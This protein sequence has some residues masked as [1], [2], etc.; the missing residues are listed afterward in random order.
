MLFEEAEVS[1]ALF[2]L[3]CMFRARQMNKGVA[4]P[5]GYRIECRFLPIYFP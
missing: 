1:A 3:A 2:D 5:C 4:S